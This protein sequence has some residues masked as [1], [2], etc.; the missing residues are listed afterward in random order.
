MFSV[1]TQAATVASVTPN[2]ATINDANVGSQT[3]TLTV[4]YS[5]AMDTSQ[6]PTISFPTAGED[7]TASPAAI[8]FHSGGWTNSTTY[9]ATYDVTN[10]SVTIPAIDVQVSGGQAAGGNAPPRL[11]RPT[12]SAS[13]P[14][15]RP[16]PASRPI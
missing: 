1:Q 11:R 10:A 16:S 15:P 2:H 4:A 5:Q 14:W 8:S 13:T 6:N 3:F 9:V 12:P 7:P